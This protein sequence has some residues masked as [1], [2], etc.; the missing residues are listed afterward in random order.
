MYF[1][2]HQA[3]E[4]CLSVLQAD[5]CQ[6]EYWWQAFRYWKIYIKASASLTEGFQD[7]TS[8][9]RGGSTVR[10]Y[11]INCHW[12]NFMY[13]ACGKTT[14]WNNITLANA[15]KD[16]PLSWDC[17]FIGGSFQILQHNMTD[18]LYFVYPVPMQFKNP[19]FGSVKSYNLQAQI[20]LQWKNRVI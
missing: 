14:Y 7:A 20:I 8:I 17:P 2:F 1:P 10:C 19:P 3:W 12:C 18:P 13:S 6:G 4:A 15:V 11:E 9:S 5:L 16:A